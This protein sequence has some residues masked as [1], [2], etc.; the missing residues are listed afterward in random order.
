MNMMKYNIKNT[1]GWILIEFIFY[2]AFT[3]KLLYGYDQFNIIKT[4]F[5]CYSEKKKEKTMISKQDLENQKTIKGKL[6]EKGS[7]KYIN[8]SHL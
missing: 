7:P 3:V 8:Q 6:S 2:C 4:F 1:R 5:F